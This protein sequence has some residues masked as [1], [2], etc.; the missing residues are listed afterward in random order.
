MPLQLT[1]IE[2]LTFRRVSCIAY[3]SDRSPSKEKE[4]NFASILNDLFLLS[5]TEDR[6]LGGMF[7]EGSMEGRLG[8]V[9]GADIRVGC[10]CKSWVDL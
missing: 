8:M 2:L 7:K 1:Q 4:K 3:E 10:L 6:G 5:R 9:K